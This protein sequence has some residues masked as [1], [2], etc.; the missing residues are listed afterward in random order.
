MDQDLRAGGRQKGGGPVY[1]VSVTANVVLVALI[2]FMA[3]RV[4]MR[5]DPQVWLV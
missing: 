5:R 3:T 1:I 4:A 2:L